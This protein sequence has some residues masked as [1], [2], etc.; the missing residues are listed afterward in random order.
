MAVYPALFIDDLLVASVVAGIPS[1]LVDVLASPSV[2]LEARQ[3]PAEVGADDVAAS[4]VARARGPQEE[5][6]TLVDVCQSIMY[7]LFWSTYISYMIECV[8]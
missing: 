5:R 8:I 2:A 7:E 3:T 6:V 4:G 1:T